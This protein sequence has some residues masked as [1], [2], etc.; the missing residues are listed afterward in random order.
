MIKWVQKSLSMALLAAILSLS[1]S[2]AFAQENLFDT[3]DDIKEKVG[4][5][6]T[7]IDEGGKVSK[8]AVDLVDFSGNN[9]WGNLPPDLIDA[10]STSGFTGLEDVAAKAKY[11]Q[12]QGNVQD[13]IDF[14]NKQLLID[15]T[16]NDVVLNEDNV[17]LIVNEIRFR[18]ESQLQAVILSV[19]KVIRNIVGT[20]AILWI[21]VAGIQLIFAQGD[22]SRI[23][24][25]KNAITW[26]LIGLAIVLLLERGIVILYG[27]PGVERG[28]QTSGT[29]LSAEVLGIVSFIKALIGA[30]AVLMI[31]VSGVQTITA[32]G[33][34]EKLT[35]EKRSVL[36]IIIGIVLIVINQFV[37][38]NLFIKP[39]LRQIAGESETITQ[40]NVQ[41][42]INLF[43]T[44]T[45][46]ILGFVGVIAFG[47]LI[48]GA[49]SLI[50]NF[51]DD[52]AIE[53]AKKVIKNALIG[54]I[55]VISA[56]AIVSTL[57]KF[58]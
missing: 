2:F 33:E 34:D 25:Q 55:V 6:Q 7:R 56:F 19:A 45:Q 53:K 43:G 46:F 1:V 3:L 36:W 32:Q 11:K 47:A 29:A 4:E 37:V 54:I 22:E 50:G 26:A 14:L 39:S 52:E 5:E 35:Q 38:E 48:Y 30:G 17:N 9:A 20:I 23:T 44:I 15:S 49:A 42:L 57:I 40:S 12:S 21:V 51:G 28:L 18:G 10:L 8:T 27:V 24:E 58:Q 41:N 13:L 16:G 31:I